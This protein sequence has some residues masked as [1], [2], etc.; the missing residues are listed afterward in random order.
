VTLDLEFEFS[1]PMVAFVV[2]PVFTGIANDLVDSFHRRA[3]DLYG[4]PR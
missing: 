4:R 2:K 3:T 1:N